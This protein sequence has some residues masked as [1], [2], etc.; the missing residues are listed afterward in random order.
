MTGPTRE[1]GQMLIQL[2]TLYAHS[3]GPRASNWLWSDEFVA[4]FDE[5]TRRFPPGSEGSR[6]VAIVAGFNETLA[7]LVKHDL[8]DAEL[9]HDWWASDLTWQKIGG[10]LAGWREQAGDK[11]LYENFE[12]MAMAGAAVTA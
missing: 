1:D 6:N 3:D 4:D 8:I 7:T 11:R 10:I 2:A 9:V 12:A 5:F